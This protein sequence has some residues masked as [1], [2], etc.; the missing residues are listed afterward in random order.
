M[1]TLYITI[2]LLCR[3]AQHLCNKRSSNLMG[4]TAMFLRY[5]GLRQCLSALLALGVILLAGNGFRVDRMTVLLSALSGAMLVLSMFCSIYAMKSGTMPLVSLFGTAGLLVPTFAGVFL[6][7]I[8]VTTMQWAGVALFLVA[9]WFMISASKEVTGSFTWRTLA[10]L[11]G[12][13][14][15]SG[16]TMLV[17]QMFTAYVPEGD[18]S[19]F[20]FLS[21]GLLGAVLLVAAPL[22]AKVSGEAPEPLPYKMLLYGFVLSSAVLIINQL[23]T[24]ATALVAPVILF[25]FINGG[26]TIISAVVAAVVFK[27]NLTFRSAA[28]IAL[29]ISALALIKI[30]AA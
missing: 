3:V 22:Y 13:T 12:S 9:A 20:S 6:F 24:L 23:A 15:T 26:S 1:S 19:V 29:G 7:H 4:G 27:E 18:V 8:P 10:L 2:I 11:V 25:T 30:F 14:L 28:G 17:Q 16:G 5:S 21:F